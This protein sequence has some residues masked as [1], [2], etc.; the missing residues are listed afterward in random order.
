[1]RECKVHSFIERD[2]LVSSNDVRRCL[3]TNYAVSG[4]LH[5]SVFP[6]DKY[7]SQS[8]SYPTGSNRAIERQRFQV[9]YTCDLI[10]SGC[11]LAIM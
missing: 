11:S 7:V 5:G 3:A 9:F 1:M 8:K 10:L 6:T 2:C 4:R